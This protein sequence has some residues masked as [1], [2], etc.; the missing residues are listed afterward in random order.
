MQINRIN[1]SKSISHCI[2]YMNRFEV[3]RRSQR[4]AQASISNGRWS[5]D[6]QTNATSGPYCVGYGAHDLKEI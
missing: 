2:S 6:T 3:V 4:P 1:N 5:F